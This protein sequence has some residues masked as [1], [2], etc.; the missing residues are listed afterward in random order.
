[1]KGRKE[2]GREEGKERRMEG[3]KGWEE[4][5]RWRAREGSGR[6]GQGGLVLG[7]RARED[8]TREGGKEGG[9]GRG[10]GKVR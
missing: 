10:S 4:G 3:W 1:M 8:M 5:P 7:G 6:K 9:P 2:V